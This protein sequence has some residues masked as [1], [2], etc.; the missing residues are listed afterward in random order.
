[1]DKCTYCAGDPEENF[2]VGEFCKYGRNRLAE[3]KLPARAEMCSKASSPA[4]T[5]SS[6]RST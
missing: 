1:M 4:A 5:R 3:G 6:P 2:S